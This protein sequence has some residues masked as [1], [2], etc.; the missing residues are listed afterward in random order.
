ML[1]N[2]LLTRVAGEAERLS[3]KTVNNQTLGATSTDTATTSKTL[4]DAVTSA[5]S[6]L[7]E[8][9]AGSS[10]TTGRTQTQEN[11]DSGLLSLA[12]QLSQQESQSESTTSSKSKS[13]IGFSAVGMVVFGLMGA[14]KDNDTYRTLQ[15]FASNHLSVKEKVA[16][17]RFSERFANHVS[18]LSN[19]EKPYAL[20]ELNV[21]Y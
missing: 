18:S 3:A 14:T 12:Q 5:M 17:Y 21:Q 16:Y 13:K 19:Y 8:R 15:S 20:T 6:R 11:T 1:V 7:S 2:D 9:S 10:G 4:V